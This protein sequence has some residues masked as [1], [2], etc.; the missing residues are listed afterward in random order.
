MKRVM[1]QCAVLSAASAVITVAA[2][3]NARAA[4]SN[5]PW[6]QPLNQILQSVEGPVAKILAVI[7]IIVTG[8]TLAFGDT[9]L[10]RIKKYCRGWGANIFVDKSCKLSCRSLRVWRSLLPLIL[11]LIRRKLR[12]L[13]ANPN[14]AGQD[15]QPGGA[16]EINRQRGG[17]GGPQGIAGALRGRVRMSDF[18][19]VHPRELLAKAPDLDV[20]ELEFTSY[21]GKPI[22]SAHLPDG[23]TQLLSLDG[24]RIEGFDT[25]EIID[26]TKRTLSESKIAALEVIDQYDLY[27]L[28]RTRQRPL[29]VIRVLMNDEER[30]RYYID[31]KSAQVVTTY[32]DRN[33]V[34]R[35][36]YTGLH[37]LNFPFLYNHRPLWD[38]VVIAFM[39]GGTGLSITSL[40]LGWRVLGRKLKRIAG[41]APDVLAP[42]K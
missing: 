4:G 33:W 36:L 42:A 27:Y 34:N 10:K 1:L 41:P 24:A 14:G 26:L 25:Q 37:S 21:A 32:S 40:V 23:K 31:P 30:T 6:E 38:I 39:L 18:A 28:D 17:R 20:R 9:K 5:M 22:F 19:S 16:Q 35:W 8:L 11:K 15:G 3:S 2:A 13:W 7:I 12:F 29:P